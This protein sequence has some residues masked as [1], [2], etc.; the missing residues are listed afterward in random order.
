[1]RM[2]KCPRIKGGAAD[3]TTAGWRKLHRTRL[4]EP[5]SLA[6]FALVADTGPDC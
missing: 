3:M 5:S 6:P 1:M 4:E 2:R